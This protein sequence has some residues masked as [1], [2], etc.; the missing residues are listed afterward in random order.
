VGE[1]GEQAVERE[2]VVLG[3]REAGRLAV[4]VDVV[5]LDAVRSTGWVNFSTRRRHRR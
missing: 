3:E 5:G 1:A 4:A 2:L